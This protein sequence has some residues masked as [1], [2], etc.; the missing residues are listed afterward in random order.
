MYL[1]A[2]SL[3]IRIPAILRTTCRTLANA[4]ACAR[5]VPNPAHAA[6]CV[7][8]RTAFLPTRSNLPRSAKPPTHAKKETVKHRLTP[9]AAMHPPMRR[10]LRRSPAWRTHVAT[11][12]RQVWCTGFIV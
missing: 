1:L 11:H 10:S 9:R 7:N 5:H 12:P 4:P 6:E 3:A 8:R 2:R